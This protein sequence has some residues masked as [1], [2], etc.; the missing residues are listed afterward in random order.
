MGLKGI[1]WGVTLVALLVA[2]TAT[3]GPFLV[4]VD[5]RALQGMAGYIAFD[6]VAGSVPTGNSA[7]VRSFTTD[8]SLTTSKS[9]GDVRGNLLPGPLSLGSTQFFNEWLQQ[10]GAFGSTI[11]FELDLGDAAV[12]GARADQFSFFLLDPNQ[13]P[14]DTS[15][16]SGAGALFAIDLTGPAAAPAV[17][18]AASASASVSP[19]TRGLPE[20]S[21]AL[22]MLVAFAGLAALNLRRIRRE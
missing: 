14:I 16:P 21:S 13:I 9:S 10:V 18:S 2:R 11:G 19:L 3:A 17:F 4:S 22:L 6:F 20:P 1:R 5:T 8:G 12:P 7:S 15:D